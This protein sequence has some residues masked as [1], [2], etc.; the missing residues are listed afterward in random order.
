MRRWPKERTGTSAPTARRR[1]VLDVAMHGLFRHQV[2]RKP[3]ATARA[4]GRTSG[5]GPR[6]QVGAAQL[7]PG[8]DQADGA[9][10]RAHRQRL[11]QHLVGPEADPAQELAVGDAGGGEEDVVAPDQVV[12]GEHLVEVVAGVEGGPALVVV[13][14]PEAAVHGAVEALEGAGGDHRLGGAADADQHVDTGA[15]AGG[16]DGPGDVAVGDQLDPGPG[17]ADLL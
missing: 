6:D 1:V 17:G 10:D 11:G 13:A 7:M 16:H 12:D 14:G 8:L 3:R 9:R 15:L 5:T 2:K 4:W